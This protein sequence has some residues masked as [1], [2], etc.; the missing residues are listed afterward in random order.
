MGRGRS[1]LRRAPLG[2][3]SLF[4]L[5]SWPKI[6]HLSGQYMLDVLDLSLGHPMC[7]H[8]EHCTGHHLWIGAAIVL[9]FPL[10]ASQELFFMSLSQRLVSGIPAFVVKSTDQHRQL[11]AQVRHLL[12]SEAVAQGVQ[13]RSQRHAGPVLLLPT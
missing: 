9:E 2:L 13:G 3:G 11:R 8:D 4:S 7:K 10:D 1:T 6:P 5:I 12:H